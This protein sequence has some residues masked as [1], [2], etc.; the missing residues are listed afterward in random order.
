M[1]SQFDRIVQND[2]IKSLGD[3]K[4]RYLVFLLMTVFG[5]IAAQAQD[6]VIRVDTE[7]AAFEVTV[8]DSKG[9]PVRNLSAEEFRVFED[10]L[11]RR[12][13]FFQPIRKQDEGRP[14][15][16][17]FALDVS[18]S[19]TPAEIDR[20]RIAMQ[21]FTARL[22]DYNS[23]F[24]VMSFAMDVKTL[25][26]FTNLPDRLERSFGKLKRDQNGLSTH[27]YDAVDDAVR[28]LG[29]KSPKTIRNRLPKRAV[30]LITDG[31]PVGDV[32]APETVIERANLAETTVYSVILPSYSRLQGSGKPVLTP[33]EA[34]G[35]VEKTGGKSF[36]ATEKN[37]EPLFK[38]LAE[39]ITAS[40]AIAFYPN[41][42]DPAGKNFREIRIMSKNGLIVR[43][44]RSGYTIGRQD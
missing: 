43:Q 7:L 23:Y 13:D 20:L 14:L 17:V 28:L 39:E 24:A 27:A 30:I 22:A 29:R 2:M 3:E 40:Y 11:E 37:F 25:Q 6:E 32:V 5:A 41:E 44:N 12:I 21:D 16:I 38:A 9:Q 36:Y 31:F 35:L 1:S 4:F 42:N 26:G 34:S 18:G 15:S 8:T 10:G 33:L 19:M